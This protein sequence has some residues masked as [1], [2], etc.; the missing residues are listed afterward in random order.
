MIMGMVDF[1]AFMK[2]KL[3]IIKC[4]YF[5]IKTVTGTYS[6]SR[7]NLRLSELVQLSD[8]VSVNRKSTHL[9]QYM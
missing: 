3:K 1:L 8:R 6:N 2:V 9:C 7:V 4:N 5:L